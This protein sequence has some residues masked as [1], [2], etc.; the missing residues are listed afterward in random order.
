LASTFSKF[1]KPTFSADSV[2]IVIVQ[3]ERPTEQDFYQMGKNIYE[4]R[5]WASTAAAL[6][7][8]RNLTKTPP[9]KITTSNTVSDISDCDSRTMRANHA[10]I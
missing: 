4:A 2:V 1:P 8:T 6:K 10:L 9:M 3:L 7:Q 5:Q